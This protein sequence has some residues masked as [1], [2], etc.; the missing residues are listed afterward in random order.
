[1]S[2]ARSIY[3][4]LTT[5]GVDLT[6]DDIVLPVLAGLPK[7]Y[8]MHVAII[9][10]SNIELSLEDIMAK[11]LIAEHKIDTIDGNDSSSTSL[12]FVANKKEKKKC[13]YCGKTNHSEDK[14]FKK[15][16]DAKEKS[17]IALSAKTVY[18]L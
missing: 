2:R 9:E 1:M 5:A 15:Q 3:D 18:A 12:A 16:R 17:S 4:E 13:D 14:C 8:D 10:S 11:L 6:E 7:E